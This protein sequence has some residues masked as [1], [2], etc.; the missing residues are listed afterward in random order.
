MAPWPAGAG[1]D[2]GRVALPL[3]PAIHPAAGWSRPPAPSDAEL[4]RNLLQAYTVLTDSGQTDE[5]AELFTEDASWD[6][7]SL[8]YGSATGPGAIAALVTSHFDPDRL[9]FHFMGPGL[10]E[11]RSADEV[12]SWGWCIAGRQDA[13]A[14]I[15][16]D[17]YD[18]L[19]RVPPGWR[20][21]HRRLVKR[22]RDAD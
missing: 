15:Y 12:H 10:L 6:G 8:G 2:P 3:V 5:V 18:V 13:G 9:M 1:T 22:R 20:F 7:T 17:Y 11:A 16:F 14:L 21:A 4:I 19:R